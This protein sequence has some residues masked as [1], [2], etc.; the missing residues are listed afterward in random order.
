MVIDEHAEILMN[1]QWSLIYV[2]IIVWIHR[3]LIDA[4]V[5]LVFHLNVVDNAKILM[6]VNLELTTVEHKIIVLIFAVDID[7]I[8]SNVLKAMKNLEISKS[9][10]FD[11]FLY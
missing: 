6:N 4:F 10:L 1:V 2:N 8:L 5:H 9:N 3:D 11:L 7:V